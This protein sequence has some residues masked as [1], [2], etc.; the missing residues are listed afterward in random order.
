M[1]RQIVRAL[2]A[3]SVGAILVVVIQ[4]GQSNKIGVLDFV[5]VTGLVILFFY[6]NYRRNKEDRVLI[7]KKIE[8]IDDNHVFACDNILISKSETE[9]NVIKVRNDLFWFDSKQKS[10]SSPSVLIESLIAD[11]KK[12]SNENSSFNQV[13]A[14]KIIEFSLIDNVNSHEKILY[15]ERKEYNDL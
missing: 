13:M 3:L 6:Q 7:N 4:I 9:P 10:V 1:K 2:I 11:F 14:N 15:E 12:L 8:A 5:P